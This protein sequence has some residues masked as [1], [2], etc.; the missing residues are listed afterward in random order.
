M[1]DLSIITSCVYCTV[2]VLFLAFLKF[3]NFQFHKAF[4]NGEQIKVNQKEPSSVPG[5]F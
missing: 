3:T 5:N 2:D 4:D 1:T